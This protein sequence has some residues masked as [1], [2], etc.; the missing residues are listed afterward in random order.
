M[1]KLIDITGQKFNYLTVLERDGTINKKVTWK[2]QCDCGKIIIAKGDSLKRGVI[3]SCGCKNKID[4]TN[5][6]FG[7]LTAIT[8]TE[9]RDSSRSVIWKC[10]CDCG[11]TVEV[12]IRLLKSGNTKSC[13]CL[14]N[15]Q[16]IKTGQNNK[17]NLEGKRFGKL[18]VIKDSQERKDNNVLWECKCDCGTIVKIKGTSL[19][20]GVQ[21]CGCLKSKGEQKISN[22]LSQNNIKYEV[23][24]T[25]STCRFQ[26]GKLAFFDFY[27]PDYNILIEYDGEQHY[28]YRNEGWNTKENFKKTKERDIY[29]NNWCIQNNIKLIRIPYTKLNNLQLSDL[30]S[31]V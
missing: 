18:L 12:S 7:K 31:E 23:Q 25:F 9:K 4:I 24:K 22:I 10:K 28:F 19:L 11:N 6:K 8:P 5:E 16:R 20:H 30:L 29:K 1:P 17:I 14:N 2:C 27:L 15:E 26:N 21:S 3:K 13:G